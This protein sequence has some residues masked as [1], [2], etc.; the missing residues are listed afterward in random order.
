MMLRNSLS[1]QCVAIDTLR[2]AADPVRR[3]PKKQ[4][5]KSDGRQRPSAKSVRFLVGPTGEI[6]DLELVWLALKANGATHVDV[7]V[8]ADLSPDELTALRLALNRTA[9]DAEWDGQNLRSVLEQLVDVNF[10]L[11]LTGFEAPEIDHYLHLDEPHANVEEN[12][13]DIPPVEGNAL[14]APGD[15]WASETT[16]SVAAAPPTAAFVRRVLNGRTANV[17]FVDPP[18]N[19]KVDGFISGKGQHRHREFVQGAGELSTDEYFALLRDSLFV[20]KAC[21]VPD[22]AGVRLHRLAPRH[23][24]DGRRPRLRHAAIYDLRLDKD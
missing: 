14:S 18:Y 10:D 13:S 3:H 11:E 17:C 4:L 6:V 15:I 7:M 12:G 22:G 9:M 2:P 24:N 5:E 21:C 20:L 8:V 23:G 19:V 16:G 1:I